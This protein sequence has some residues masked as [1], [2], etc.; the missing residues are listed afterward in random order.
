MLDFFFLCIYS[1]LCFRVLIIGLQ[2]MNLRA[3]IITIKR[4]V[5]P[6]AEERRNSY[7]RTRRQNTIVLARTVYC[8]V[9]ACMCV[10]YDYALGWIPLYT[11]TYIHIHIHIHLYA[12]IT[13]VTTQT[14]PWQ[15][16]R[17]RRLLLRRRWWRVTLR[18]ITWYIL[19]CTHDV[20]VHVYYTCTRI[21]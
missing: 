7:Y 21:L 5:P 19:P 20:Y 18:C 4:S 8:Y 17:V 1:V 6:A 9:D 2:C 11:H 16:A 10:R 13:G 3:L 15:Y 12:Y 14:V